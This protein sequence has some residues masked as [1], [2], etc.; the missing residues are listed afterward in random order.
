MWLVES[1]AERGTRRCMFGEIQEL[2]ICAKIEVT[3]R[4]RGRNL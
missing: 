4:H 2:I 1:T 3:V